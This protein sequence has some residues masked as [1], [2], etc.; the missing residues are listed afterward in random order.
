MSKAVDL[1]DLMIHEIGGKPEEWTPYLWEM[2]PHGKPKFMQITGGIFRHKIKSGPRKGEVNY[3]KPEP[4]TLDSVVITLRERDE[5]YAAWERRTGMC[6]ECAGD[7]KVTA[8]FG[9]KNGE[10][11]CT[12]REC[13]RCSGTGKAK[14]EG[15]AE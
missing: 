14:A 9:V 2:L 13:S 1:M 5:W 11:Y 8:S 4:G 10:R 6:N 12:Y 15:G 7:G 3:G